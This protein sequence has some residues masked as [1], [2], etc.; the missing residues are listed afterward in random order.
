MW[1]K[2]FESIWWFLQMQWIFEIGGFNM[3]S[4]GTLDSSFNGAGGYK[5]G[6]KNAK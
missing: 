3:A 4:Y 5:F 2:I 6:Q 1:I